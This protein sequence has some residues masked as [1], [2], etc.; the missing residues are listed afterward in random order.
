MRKL[1]YEQ[2]GRRWE[3]RWTDNND[4]YWTTNDEGDGVFI[5]TLSRNERRQVVGTCDFSLNGLTPESA[6]RK[7][8]KWMTQE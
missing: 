5:V 2:D 3:W 4:A 7:I 8:R 6:K 1:A